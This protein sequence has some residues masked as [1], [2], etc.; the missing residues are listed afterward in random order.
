MPSQSGPPTATSRQPILEPDFPTG[1]ESWGLSRYTRVARRSGTPVRP[2]S[3]WCCARPA[4]EGWHNN[5]HHYQSSANQGFFWW[6]IDVS[7]YLIQLMGWVGVVWDIRKPPPSKV[8]DKARKQAIPLIRLGMHKDKAT[9][10]NFST[11]R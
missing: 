10:T 5:H 9:S 1:W 7:Y 2:R 8:G 11:P 3:R 4:S 6:E